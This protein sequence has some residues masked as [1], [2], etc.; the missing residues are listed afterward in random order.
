VLAGCVP[1]PGE[2]LSGGTALA[3][4]TIAP[5]W[6]WKAIPGLFSGKAGYPGMNLQI[7]ATLHGAGRR[8]RARTGA[9][10]A[11]RRARIR[12]LRPQGPQAVACPS[13]P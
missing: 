6:D 9:R 11:P 2:I 4:G 3:D 12:R 8:N 5:A 7:A 13:Q 10:R 1:D